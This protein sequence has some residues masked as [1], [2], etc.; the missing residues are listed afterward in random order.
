MKFFLTMN[1]PSNSGKAVH[2]IVCT[3]PARTLSEFTDLINGQDFITV[4][5]LYYKSDSSNGDMFSRGPIS[6]NCLLIGKVKA[7]D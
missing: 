1:M 7:E 6:L 5:E 4:D 2:Q 3:H